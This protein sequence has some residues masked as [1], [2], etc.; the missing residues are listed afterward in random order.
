MGLLD[1]AF[2]SN[3]V[4]ILARSAISG[5][6]PF[7]TLNMNTGETVP[8][9]YPY[10][11]GVKVYRGASGALYAVAVSEQPE[12]GGSGGTTTSILQL[13]LTNRADTVRLVDYHG[14]DT[15]FSLAESSGGL[16]ATIGG[17]GAAIYSAS[18]VQNLERAAGLPHRLLN[19]GQYLINLD[20][21]GSILWHDS[22]S[23]KLLA[24]FRLRSSTW[25][26]QTEQRT[27]S[28]GF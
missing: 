10:S 15:Q 23:G 25:T 22:N 13:N 3:T 4:L 16:A 26:L 5:N 20:M 24:I 6:S 14:E 9:S 21:D 12:Q 2:I 7:M 1:A 8:L 19:G 17:E 28:G 18:Q 27:I 11:A